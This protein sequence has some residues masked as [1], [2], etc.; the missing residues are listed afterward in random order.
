MTEV[1]VQRSFDPP[2]T[3]EAFYESLRNATGCFGLYRVQWRQSLLSTD[4]RRMICWLSG[5]DVESTRL[6]LRKAGSQEGAAWAGSIH[7]APAAGAPPADAANVVVERSFEEP[8]TLEEIQAIEDAG[9]SCLETHQVRFVRT[10]FSR[11]RKRMA[12]LYRAP[13]AEAVRVAQR[14]AGM[15]VDSVWSFRLLSG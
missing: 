13:D 8:V 10:F 1:F 15:P 3:D 5:P 9:A 6:A 14:M 12:C 7:D 2:L 4:G 11:D